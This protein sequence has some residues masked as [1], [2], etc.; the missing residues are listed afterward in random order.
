MYRM[1]IPLIALLAVALALTACSDSSDTS[2]AQQGGGSETTFAS[3]GPLSAAE[4]AAAIRALSENWGACLSAVDVE[5]ADATAEPI[6]DEKTGRPVDKG[7]RPVL[8]SVKWEDKTVAFLVALKGP[9][10]NGAAARDDDARALIA[11]AKAAGG[12][13]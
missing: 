6:D 9:L 7:N 1:K 11:A 13:C 5:T 12:D 10:Q 4:R 3:S 2:D 8:V